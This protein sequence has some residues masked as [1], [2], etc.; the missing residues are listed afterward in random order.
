MDRGYNDYDL[1]GAWT[2]RG[3]FFVTRLKETLLSKNGWHR[4]KQT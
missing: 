3:I 2:D 4:L 1:F